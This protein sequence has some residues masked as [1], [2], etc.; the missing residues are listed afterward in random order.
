LIQILR[1]FN[2][3]IIWLAYIT[4]IVTAKVCCYGQQLSDNAA[5]LNFW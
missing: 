2:I 3:Y 5:S 1:D 4:N